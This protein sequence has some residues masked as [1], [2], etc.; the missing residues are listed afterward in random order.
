MFFLG[1]IKDY[2]KVGELFNMD[3]KRLFYVHFSN[4]DIIIL[5]NSIVYGYLP[6]SAG[7]VGQWFFLIFKKYTLPVHNDI[8]VR[9]GMQVLLVL[10][11][12]KLRH[13]HTIPCC[14]EL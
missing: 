8:K 13:L 12:S 14:K 2:C 6:L 7:I 9:L 3:Y 1:R 11:Y 10:G 4:I 5:T